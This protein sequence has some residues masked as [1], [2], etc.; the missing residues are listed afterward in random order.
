ML[1]SFQRPPCLTER[2]SFWRRP[3]R[4]APRG[5]CG[6]TGEYSAI[7]SAACGQP[8]RRRRKRRLPDLQD[9]P[10][11][12]ARPA[13]SCSPACSGSS[14]SAHAALVDQPAGLR[15]R[16]AE[17]SAIRPGRWT[18][19]SCGAEDAPPRS[20]RAPRAATNTRSKCASAAGACVLG[21]TARRP[22]SRA[23]ARLASRGD[24]VARGRELPAEQQPEYSAIASSGIAIV[25]PY[26]SCGGSVTPIWLPSDLDIL[27]CPSVPDQD[28]HR[29]DRLLGLAVGALDVAPEQKV[30]LLVGAA[31]LD[32]GAHRHRVIAL[33]QRVEQLEHRDRLAAPTSVWRSRRA[34][35]AAP[36]VVVRTRPSSSTIGM[37][38]HSLLRRTSRRSGSASRI[39]QRLLLEG[40]GVGVDLLGAEHRAQARASRGIPDA[41][42]VVADDQHDAV[43]GVLELAQLAQHDR[44]AEVDVGR[45]RVDPQLDPQRAALRARPSRASPQAPPR[46]GSRPRRG[47]AGRLRSAAALVVVWHGV[48]MLD[49]RR[50]RRVPSCR[51]APRPAPS[52]TVPS[53]RLRALT[54]AAADER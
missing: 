32:V 13:T 42:G 44:V 54:A 52:E 16:D 28:R 41:G 7:S 45:R 23:S 17:L 18:T 40:R 47:P 35:A 4:P 39:L 22:V 10:V 5:A 26:I 6:P 43:P 33:Q 53:G 1:L 25:L 51:A 14:S 12:R 20:P 46:A 48:A 30:E 50:S 21:V 2:G 34:R 29:Q 36:T 24:E 27:R 49:S 19:P 3:I 9:R 11:E 15:A 31:E 8:A 38:S 37:S